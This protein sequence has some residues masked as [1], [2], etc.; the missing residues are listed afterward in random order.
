M[1]FQPVHLVD[2]TSTRIA[3]LSIQPTGDRYSGTISLNAMPPQLKH[4]FEEFEEMVE[5]Q[6]FS[7]AD[8][9]EEKI[10]ALPLKVVFE[11]G[12]E[13]EVEDLQ[14]YPS[15]K[16]VSFKTRQPATVAK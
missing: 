16:R 10:A 14:I 5:G 15:T 7:L 12:T 8:E 6:M 4:L 9:I 11:N 1:T 3:C 2:Q 13:A